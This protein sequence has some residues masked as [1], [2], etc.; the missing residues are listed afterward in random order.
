MLTHTCTYSRTLRL[1]NILTRPDYPQERQTRGD[2]IEVYEILNGH[3]H[4]N[5][6]QFFTVAPRNN[7]RV[8]TR[9]HRTTLRNRLFSAR[10]AKKIE[11]TTG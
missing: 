4:I 3:D 6:D 8:E 11:R 7:D 5:P 9:G 10:I 2:L 1:D